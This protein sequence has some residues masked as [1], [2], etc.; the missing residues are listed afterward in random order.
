MIEYV[1]RL[2]EIPLKLIFYI[3]MIPTFILENQFYLLI[4]LAF[5]IIVNTMK[6]NKE[7]FITSIIM[8]ISFFLT[9]TLLNKIEYVEDMFGI[10]YAT[11]N[12]IF[13]LCV[14]FELIYFISFIRFYI[15]LSKTNSEKEN[16]DIIQNEKKEEKIEEKEENLSLKEGTRNQILEEQEYKSKKRRR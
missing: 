5:I 3:L 15:I 4:I 9:S 12:G 7:L 11:V 13:I 14:I 16:Q 2:I 8:I 1:L 10:D 6:K